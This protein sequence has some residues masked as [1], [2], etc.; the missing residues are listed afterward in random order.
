M[1]PGVRPEDLVASDQNF[2][3]GRRLF[4]ERRRLRA[5][6]RGRGSASKCSKYEESFFW[7]TYVEVEDFLTVLVEGLSQKKERLALWLSAD[8]GCD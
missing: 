6:K 5:A 1:K 4:D 7:D 3:D 2:E 8:A